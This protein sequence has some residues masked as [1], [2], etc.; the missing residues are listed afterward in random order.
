MVGTTVHLAGAIGINPDGTLSPD[1]TVQAR[2]AF[3]LLEEVLKEAGGSLAD[4]VKTT[5]FITDMRYRDGY[6]EARA[7]FFA[8][9][10]PASTL[11]QCVALAVPG[12]LIEIEGIAE[13]GSGD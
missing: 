9:N 7:E 4:L 13:L 11:V 6:N 10:P 3:Q 5:V 8:E 2:R 1:V 12:A